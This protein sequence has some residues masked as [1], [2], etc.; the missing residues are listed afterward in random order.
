MR[1]YCGDNISFCYEMYASSEALIASSMNVEDK[2]YLL[3]PDGG[4]YEFI[5]VE[6]ESIKP[7]LMNE[8]EVGKLYEIVVTNLSGLYRYKIKD[9][10]R[11]T[12]FVGENP[13]L[14]FAYRKEQVINMGG[15]HLTIEHITNA[16]KEFEKAIGTQI[17]DYSLYVNIDHVPARIEIFIETENEIS[18]EIQDKIVEIF[19]EKLANVNEEHGRMIRV[20]ESAHSVVHC[21][22]KG[23][24]SRYRDMKIKK[25]VPVN[26]IKTIRFIDTK[27]KLEYFLNNVK[28]KVTLL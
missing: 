24:Y 11:V 3:I 2:N 5:P 21:V 23:T 25:G 13:L 1:K 4:F 17:T 20:G 10:I 14:Q 22:E 19:D 6:E 27:E 28:N 7:L 16:I 8:L 9:V 12:G 26:Q 18:E 15:V